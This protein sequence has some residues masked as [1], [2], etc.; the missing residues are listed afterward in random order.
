MTSSKPSL[1]D[2]PCLLSRKGHP[3]LSLRWGGGGS[4]HRLV[5][6]LAANERLSETP[7]PPS[8]QQAAQ[9]ATPPVSL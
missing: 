4:R 5:S 2:A 6:P 1:G 7:L 8:K 3:F 9:N